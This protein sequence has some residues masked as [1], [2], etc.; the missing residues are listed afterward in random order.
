MSSSVSLKPHSIDPRWPEHIE[1]RCERVSRVEAPTLVRTLM[2]QSLKEI[3][4]EQ[5]IAE[6]TVKAH[7]TS[8]YRKLGVQSKYE[9]LANEYRKVLL[10]HPGALPF[11]L[12]F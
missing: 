12:R 5:N 8:I 3:A 2:G 6:K 1:F 7:L 10:A 4:Y 11:G 9:L